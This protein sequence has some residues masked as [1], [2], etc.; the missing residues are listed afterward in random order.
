M[1]DTTTQGKEEIFQ[2]TFTK[3]T[4]IGNWYLDQ[5]RLTI[6]PSFTWISEN[7]YIPNRTGVDKA[8]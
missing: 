8:Y 1:N 4:P 2:Q 3:V 7:C 6:I 5:V